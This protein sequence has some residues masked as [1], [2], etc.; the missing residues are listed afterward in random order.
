MDLEPMNAAD[1]RVV[2]QLAAEYGLTSDSVDEGRDRHI[3]LKK[4]SD[5]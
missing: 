3:V 2:H 5:A 1:R 4:A